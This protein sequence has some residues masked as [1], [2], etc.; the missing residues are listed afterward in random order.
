MS[1]SPLR[2]TVTDNGREFPVSVG[3]QEVCGSR[4]KG[5]EH[6]GKNSPVLPVQFT[7]SEEV[8]QFAHNF[9]IQNLTLKY[10]HHTPVNI[11]SKITMPKPNCQTE[12][13]NQ[14]LRLRASNASTQPE[15]ATTS[16]GQQRI[17]VQRVL[18]IIESALQILDDDDL[19]SDLDES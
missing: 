13:S 6:Q 11:A 8:I 17:K 9:Q 3:L 19:F 16:G 4:H 12:N 5:R 10:H 7:V 18:A 15:G 1:E 2:T 14:L